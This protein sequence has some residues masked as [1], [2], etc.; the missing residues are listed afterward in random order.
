M[1]SVTA[2]Q[3]MA[4]SRMPARRRALAV[5]GRE[6]GGVGKTA[7]P[8]VRRLVKRY[9]PRARARGRPQ[10]DLEIGSVARTDWYCPCTSGLASSGGRWQVNIAVGRAGTWQPCQRH[11][12]LPQRLLTTVHKNKRQQHIGK[13]NRLAML[14]PTGGK[15]N[16]VVVSD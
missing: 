11:P 10:N 13:L 14:L 1:V 9:C 12:G 2:A 15:R 5:L 8:G 6:T 3:V 16:Q 7:S 4:G